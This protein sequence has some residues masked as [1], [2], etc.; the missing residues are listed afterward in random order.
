MD[1]KLRWSDEAV[2]N[3]DGILKDIKFKWS[4][5]EVDIFKGKLSHQLDLI[6]QNPYIFP[7]ST[8]KNG[9]RKAVL[10]KQTTIFYEIMEDK[11]YLAYLHVNKMDINNIK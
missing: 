10:S 9:L 7:A 11:V 5:K 1:F 2:K 3:L 6:V 4:D 8:I